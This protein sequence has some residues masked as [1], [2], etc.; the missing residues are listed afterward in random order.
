MIWSPS[1]A[2]PSRPRPASGRRRRRTRCRDRAR[3]STTSRQRREVGG[4]AADVD[5][6]AVG[7]PPIGVHLGAEPLEGL[8]REP[9]YAPFAQSTAIAGPRGRSR[10]A[11]AR[12]RGSCRRRPRRGRSAPALAGRSSSASISSSCS[13]ESL[14][15]SRSKNLTPL[16]SGGLCDAETTAPRSSASSATAGVGSTPAS[17]AFP[18]AATIPRANASSSSGPKRGCR[19]RRRRARGPT[20]GRG[21]AEPLHELRRQFSPTTPR[22]PSVPKYR[23]APRRG[24][25]ALARTAGPCGPCAGRPSCAPPSVRR[26]SGSPRA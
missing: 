8:R 2:S 23:H 6:R 15:P 16:Y 24:T 25:L 18:P 20:R 3:V 19:G 9:A 13:S 4:A 11:R 17:T 14:W 12:A 21:L 5:V 10:S 26:A 22:T 7:P 1:T